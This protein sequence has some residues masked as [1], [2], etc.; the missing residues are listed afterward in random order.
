MALHRWCLGALQR[1]D[2]E[3]TARYLRSTD[4]RRPLPLSP[5]YPLGGLTMNRPSFLDRHP[6]LAIAFMFVLWLAIGIAEGMGY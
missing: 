3:R 2:E 6:S 5:L 1:A 4:H